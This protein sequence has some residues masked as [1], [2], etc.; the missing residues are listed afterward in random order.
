M[1]ADRAWT[2]D[3]YW[4]MESWKTLESIREK[5]LTYPL[6]ER[7]GVLA[8]SIAQARATGRSRVVDLA[9][10]SV[11]AYVADLLEESDGE[12]TGRA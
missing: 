9:S 7:R 2:A 11:Y 10:K 5:L 6:A 8:K 3:D 4:Q 1:E 12:S